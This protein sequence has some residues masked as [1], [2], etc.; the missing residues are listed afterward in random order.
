MGYTLVTHERGYKLSF[1][2]GIKSIAGGISGAPYAIRHFQQGHTVIAMIQFIP[3][4]GAIAAIFER[5]VV[6]LWRA[7]LLPKAPKC[8]F[9]EPR[10]LSWDQA[11]NKMVKNGKKA[12]Q[13][14]LLKDPAYASLK[15]GF[16]STQV[17]SR[18]EPLPLTFSPS[19]AQALGRRPYME[20]ARFYAE[21]DQG[22]ITGVFDGH[23]GKDAAEYASREFEKRFVPTLRSAKGNIHQAF[24]SLTHKIH[25]EIRKN[26]KWKRMGSTA[27]VSFIDKKSHLIYTSTLGD[28]EANIYRIINGQYK[29]I[30]LSCVR[31][32][33]SKNDA[34]RAARTYNDPSIAINWPKVDNPKH[35]RS[36]ITHGGNNSRSLGDFQSA[37]TTENPLV[38]DKPK[39]SMNKLEPGDLVL[40]TSDGKDALRESAIVNQVAHIA[41]HEN[42]AQDLTDYATPFI[43]DN[44]TVTAI[45]IGLS[46][47][48]TI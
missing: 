45:R 24:E 48:P 10:Q 33:S 38:I 47:I 3:I 6:T 14:H 19:F 40:F 15:E 43:R 23:G 35:L 20:D 28:S 17:L 26:K 16:P 44:L 8:S 2:D 4:I 9:W 42:I 34:I 29:S 13:E 27:L 30:P 31:D 41:T 18:K 21:I 7:L 32:W 11:I 36:K 25:L 1:Y 46:P 12:I 37:G 22:I 39:I 5:L